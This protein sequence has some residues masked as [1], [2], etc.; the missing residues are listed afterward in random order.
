MLLEIFPND[1]ETDLFKATCVELY[2]LNSEVILRRDAIEAAG[3]GC[4]IQNG[5]PT[6]LMSGLLTKAEQN[7]SSQIQAP[8]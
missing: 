6:M 7:Y 5:H 1:R 4:P 2:D 8:E 3:D